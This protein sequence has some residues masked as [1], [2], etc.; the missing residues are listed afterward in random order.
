VWS[1]HSC[2][3]LAS[4]INDSIASSDLLKRGVYA[5]KSRGKDPSGLA[6]AANPMNQF[7]VVCVDVGAAVQPDVRTSSLGQLY[8]VYSSDIHEMRI[9]PVTE[10]FT[11]RPSSRASVDIM[12]RR[13][14][15]V[16]VVGRRRLVL[17][18][19]SM[20]IRRSGVPTPAQS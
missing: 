14:V 7:P 2:T 11:F 5:R 10:S 6:L 8:T 9:E 16:R 1:V 20:R 17:E 3:T 4:L 18:Y 19:I 15:D 13:L 12:H